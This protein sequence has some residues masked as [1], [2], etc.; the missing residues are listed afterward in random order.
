[1][2]PIQQLCPTLTSVCGRKKSS[3]CL[4]S[5]TACWSFKKQADL[6]AHLFLKKKQTYEYASGS[7]L[8]TKVSIQ[9]MCTLLIGKQL[10][11]LFKIKL[12]TTILF[13]VV[14][15]HYIYLMVKMVWGHKLEAHSTHIS[16]FVQSLISR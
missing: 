7:M 13:L 6:F 10:S 12:A 4:D 15:G 9:E 16:R 2:Y 1:M 5:M 8:L 3:R 11:S 14:L